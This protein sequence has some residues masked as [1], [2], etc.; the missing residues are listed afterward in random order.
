MT[1]DE[2][3][4][5]AGVM[6]G[7]VKRV[8]WNDRPCCSSAGLY[9]VSSSPEPDKDI[10]S[11]EIRFDDSSV[12]RWI[13]RLPDFTIDGA[14]P[15][16]NSLEDRLSD[17]WI[18]EE[19]ILY[20]GMT[21]KSLARRIGAY[22]STELGAGKPHSGGQWLKT[23]A[24]LAELYVYYAPS[25]NPEEGERKMLTEFYEK[26]GDYPFANLTGS[27]GRRAHGL[28]KQREK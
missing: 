19:N 26:Q 9:V 6:P 22:Y 27:Q 18:P 14:K 23:L 24:N 16:V 13:N 5:V 20:V 3:F 4:E 10:P 21:K 8:R 1:V 7:N 2:L 12:R 15:S 11:G 25:S 17:F 28:D